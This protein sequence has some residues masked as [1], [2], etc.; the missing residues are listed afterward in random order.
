MLNMRFP[1]TA[2]AFAA[3]VGVGA[4][5]AQDSNPAQAQGLERQT[6][7]NQQQQAEQYEARRV[8]PDSPQQA[9]TVQ[10]ALVDKLRMRNNAEIELAK[11]AQQ[12]VEHQELKQLTQMLIQDHQALNQEL[13]KLTGQQRSD[14]RPGSRDQ[15]GRSVDAQ[16]GSRQG[17][18][19][20]ES[21]TVPAEL[22]QIM[23]QAH[24]NSLQMT[25]Q[26]LSQYEG[27]DFQMGF[28]SQQIVAH[29]MMLGELKAIESSGPQEL[30]PIVQKAIQKTESHLEKSKQLAKKLEDESRRQR[31]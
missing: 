18:T 16:R 5:N 14:A 19:A 13:Q 21:A 29:T 20:S 27:Q 17:A 4:A 15:A 10:Q 2:L 9:K 30:Q 7:Q 22:C 28:L 26:M 23:E 12:K 25:K 24:Q 3:L 11:M 1:A 31:S 8:S 6:P